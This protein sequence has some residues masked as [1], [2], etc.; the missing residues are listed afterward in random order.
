MKPFFPLF[1]LVF[2]LTLPI[3]AGL[4]FD[5]SI[6]REGSDYDLIYRE[7]LK[8]QD[9]QAACLG[10]ERCKAWNFVKPSAGNPKALC[11]LKSAVPSPQANKCCV[12]GVKA[13]AQGPAD[14]PSAASAASAHPAVPDFENKGGW[15]GV[16]LQEMDADLR[17]TMGGSDQEGV[18]VLEIV[19]GSAAEKKGLK[20]GDVILA[21]DGT[22]VRTLQES[23]SLIGRRAPGE[24][25]ALLV[26]SG[27]TSR[28]IAVTLGARPAD[29]PV[30]KPPP[31]ANAPQQTLPSPAGRPPPPSGVPLAPPPLA[32][33]PPPP[34]P[35]AISSESSFDEFDQLQELEE[36]E[37]LQ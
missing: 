37:P 30:G 3:Q 8:V 25:M 18:L 29:F 31:P 12:S 9:C 11:S 1:L 14:T 5:E 21:I 22:P 16:K 35:G 10:D 36:L 19:P 4:A 33:V 6:L 34:L 28:F 20:Q 15:L 24:K 23:L 2:L 32:I 17:A 13:G 26:Q 7:G 27:G